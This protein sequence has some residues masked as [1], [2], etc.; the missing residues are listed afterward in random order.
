MPV[1]GLLITL[2]ED[3]EKVAS[4]TEQ[5][6]AREEIELGERTGRYLPIVIDAETEAESRQ[7]YEWIE[8][9]EGVYFVD[10]VFSSVDGPVQ[11]SLI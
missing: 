3:P 1:K 2:I 7:L 8:S 11:G 9:L 6:N 5:L 4:A 10:T